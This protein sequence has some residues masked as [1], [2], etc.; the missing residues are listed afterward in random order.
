MTLGIGASGQEDDARDAV[1]LGGAGIDDEDCPEPS[2][3][4]FLVERTVRD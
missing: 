3:C 4:S 2:V 1:E